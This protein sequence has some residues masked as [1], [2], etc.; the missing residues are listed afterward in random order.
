MAD[1][2]DASAPSTSSSRVGKLFSRMTDSIGLSSRIITKDN[3]DTPLNSMKDLLMSKNVAHDTAVELCQ[4]IGEQLT[5]QKVAGLDG[6]AHSMIVFLYVNADSAH[7]R[8]EGGRTSDGRRAH[9]ETD[10]ED[11]Q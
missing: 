2:D 5:G 4:S 1:Y 10:A 11:V 9:S 8:L 7:R 3:L 6:G